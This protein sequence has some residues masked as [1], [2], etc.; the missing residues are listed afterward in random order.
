MRCFFFLLSEGTS[1]FRTESINFLNR[2]ITI[3]RARWQN[4]LLLISCLRFLVY[5]LP[6]AL[7][8]VRIYCSLFSFFF[9][10]C[11]F[12]VYE[13]RNETQITRQQINDNEI[14]QFRNVNKCDL[15]LS[16]TKM[17]GSSGFCYRETISDNP[18]PQIR[19]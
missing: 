11:R 7:N 14:H 4:Y 2:Y 10:R 17:C 9:P 6:N 13:N 5:V 19:M 8:T 12:A 18:S 3:D 1:F 15:I 16:Q